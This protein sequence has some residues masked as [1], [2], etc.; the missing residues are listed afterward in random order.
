MKLLI[1]GAEQSLDLPGTSTFQD[2]MQVVNHAAVGP[3][4]SVT[5]VSLNGQDIT[6]TD[7]QAYS[8]LTLEQIEQIEIETGS[9]TELAR[10]T[11]VSLE[12]FM[13]DL[14]REL[15]RVAEMFRS[16]EDVCAAELYSQSLDGIQVINYAASKVLE[17]L[18]IDTSGITHN[19]KSIS[20]IF[21]ELD[22]IISDMMHSQEQNDWILLADLI[23]Y[24]L[25]PHI[26][27]R[28]MALSKVG[29][30][31]SETVS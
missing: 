12:E 27:D 24:E 28:Q 25:I 29:E 3:G 2:V 18:G 23:E 4:K 20:E 31:S 30:L 17:N 26:A 7:W 1:N 11:L 6:G 9:L 16:G 10:E 19:G 22:N 8:P 21:S 15:N 5:R 14:L 13:S